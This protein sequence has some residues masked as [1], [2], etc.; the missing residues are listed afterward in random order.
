MAKTGNWRGKFIIHDINKKDFFLW[1]YNTVYKG[2]TSIFFCLS[3]L[4]QTKLG[5]AMK[6]K[7]EY[8]LGIFAHIV[9]LT[10]IILLVFFT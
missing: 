4:S 10:I 9:Y 2:L 5:G 6:D 3:F 8:Y 1:L 7:K